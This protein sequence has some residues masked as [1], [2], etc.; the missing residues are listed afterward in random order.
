[1]D[2]ITKV[3]HLRSELGKHGVVKHWVMD[4]WKDMIGVKGQSQEEDLVSLRHLSGTD[5]VHYTREAYEN[6]AL[7]IH[8]TICKKESV[9]A[10]CNVQETVRARGDSTS[11]GEAL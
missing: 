2:M 7:A 10:P 4:G 3:E 9:V 6:L 8:S 1:M 11:S 5:N